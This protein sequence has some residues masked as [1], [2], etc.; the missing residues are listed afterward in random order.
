MCIRRVAHHLVWIS[1][2]GSCAGGVMPGATAG[3]VAVLNICYAG[4]VEYVWERGVR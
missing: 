4:S 1:P 3:G 2:L